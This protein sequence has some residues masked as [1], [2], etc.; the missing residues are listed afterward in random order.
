MIGA[1]TVD[2]KLAGGEVVYQFLCRKGLGQAWVL[3]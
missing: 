2:V 1:G 3:I